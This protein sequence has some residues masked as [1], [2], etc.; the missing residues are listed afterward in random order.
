M[1]ASFDEN[2]AR[3]HACLTSIS[4]WTKP[5]LMQFASSA[6]ISKR[7]TLKPHLRATG[8]AVH[9]IFKFFH[10]SCLKGDQK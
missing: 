2:D 4:N 6:I 8:N 7:M 9:P 3:L 10:N 5:S 1:A